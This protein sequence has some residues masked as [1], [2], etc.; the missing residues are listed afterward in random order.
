[1]RVA[2]DEQIKPKKRQKKEK[3]AGALDPQKMADSLHSGSWGYLQPL[4]HIMPSTPK[5]SAVSFQIPTHQN[6][7]VRAFRYL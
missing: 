2:E 6:P 4:T 7:P 1:M 3:K 5:T